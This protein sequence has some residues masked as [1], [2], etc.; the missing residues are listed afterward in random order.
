MELKQLTKSTNLQESFLLPQF[1]AQTTLGRQQLHQLNGLSPAANNAPLKDQLSYPG[2][3][4][5]YHLPP[6]LETETRHTTTTTFSD[7][8]LK[9]AYELKQYNN[10]TSDHRQDIDRGGGA[11]TIPEEYQRSKT[12]LVGNYQKKKEVNNKENRKSVSP[13]SPAKEACTIK[14]NDY[15]WQQESTSHFQ[16]DV[17]HYRRRLLRFSNT[18]T[19]LPRKRQEVDFSNLYGTFNEQQQRHAGRPPIVTMMERDYY[20]LANRSC[21]EEQLHEVAEELLAEH[22]E[23]EHAKLVHRM[24]MMTGG[25]AD[26]AL[27]PLPLAPNERYLLSNYNQQAFPPCYEQAEQ[28]LKRFS[29]DEDKMTK[30]GHVRPLAPLAAIDQEQEFEPK[31]YQHP[32]RGDEMQRKEWRKSEGGLCGPQLMM[33][34]PE[35]TENHQYGQLSSMLPDSGAA[36]VATGPTLTQG[37]RVGGAGG[38]PQ[39]GNGDG[40]LMSP[41]TNG[42]GKLFNRSAHYT[43]V[44]T[45]NFF[46]IIGI[47]VVEGRQS[48]NTKAL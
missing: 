25:G 29:L 2:V 19:S 14:A 30:N 7:K 9:L 36:G 41:R 13:P 6:L 15:Y 39:L 24:L 8:R 37:I 10:T 33:F 45:S 34:R 40:A 22:K 17:D 32:Q 44:C 48:V 26:A 42:P 18:G 23:Q 28:Q 31:Y 3:G 46:N 27:P 21:I 35:N 43:Q 47:T 5:P 1:K 4:L 11:A 16:L 20:R 38:E 12:K